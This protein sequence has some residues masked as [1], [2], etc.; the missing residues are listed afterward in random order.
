MRSRQPLSE[1]RPSG[2]PSLP[3]GGTVG[4][5]LLAMMP[6]ASRRTLKQLLLHG[7]VE[8]DGLQARRLDAPVAEGARVVVLPR[9]VRRPE[10]PELPVVHEDAHLI[11]VDKPAGWLTV[12]SR[13]KAKRSVWSH[14]RRTHPGARKGPG[15]L[16]VHR[17]D[18]RASGLLVFAR[19]ER[20]QHALKDLFARHDVDRH[21]AAIVK[22]SLPR[23]AG[24]FKSRLVERDDKHHTVRSLRPGEAPPPGTVAKE[25]LTR[26]QVRG[27]ASGLTAVEVRLETGRKHQIR[28][29]FAEARHPVFGDWLYGGPDAARLYLH[30]W[31][32]GFA[33]PATGAPMRFV[34]PPGPL[35]DKKIPGAFDRPG[36]FEES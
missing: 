5:R 18:E 15:V 6:G 34:S 36:D 12:S 30:A 14:L 33:H 13:D 21:Y 22:G 7:R 31:I 32:L 20:I 4:E 3:R 10:D 16:L 9:E 23:S 11:V 26:W 2:K 27:R 8:V 28:V 24:F 17:L 29:H 35:F 25:A 1:R 19:S